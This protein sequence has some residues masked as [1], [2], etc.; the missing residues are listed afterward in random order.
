MSPSTVMTKIFVTEV[1]E[2]SEKI[3]KTQMTFSPLNSQWWILRRMLPSLNNWL[4]PPATK[5]R[6]GN[7]LHLS[8]NHSVHR[9]CLP[10]VPGVWPHTPGQTPPW[11]DTPRQTPPGQT[12]GRHPPGR[13]PPEQ[14]PP[15]QTPSWADTQ[16]ADGPLSRHPPGQT[17]LGRH[18]PPGQT[19][20]GQTPLCIVHARIHT[21]P[22]LPSACWDTVNK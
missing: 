2:F 14:T 18:P 4:L 21:H 20:P 7:F 19:L 10:L 16:Q 22:P 1:A 9:E 5:L 3:G 17:P 6:Q 13:H 15:G 11:A 12:P 8:V